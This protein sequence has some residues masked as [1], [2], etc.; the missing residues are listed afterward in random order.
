MPGGVISANFSPSGPVA[1]AILRDGHGRHA[2]V[3]MT[4]R[5]L[6]QAHAIGLHHAHARFLG[7]YE[8]LAH[9]GILAGRIGIDF[10]D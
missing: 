9:A 8:E 4:A 6:G 7:A 2:L 3:S 1:S 5:Q 10:Q